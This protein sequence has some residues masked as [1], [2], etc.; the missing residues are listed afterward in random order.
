MQFN[1]LNLS[2]PQSLYSLGM[3]PCIFSKTQNQLTGRDWFRGGEDVKYFQNEIPRK[4]NSQGNGNIHGNNNVLY[5]NN[6]AGEGLEYYFTLSFVYEF[7][8]DESEVWFA[9]AAPY[10]F[11]DLQKDLASVTAKAHGQACLNILCK[12]L[13]GSPVPMVTITDNVET[14]LDYYDQC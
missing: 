14:Y 6:G 12:E 2:K 3:K 8:Q 7:E 10:S 1:I 13:S 5:N 9:Q 11:S 4:T